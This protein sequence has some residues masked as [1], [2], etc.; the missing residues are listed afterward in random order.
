MKTRIVVAMAAAGLIPF[1]GSLHA[2]VLCTK[3]SGAVI[4][5]TGDSCGRKETRLSPATLGLQAPA[6][7]AG[8][9]GPPGQDGQDG[10]D[11]G[12]SLLPIAFGV[13]DADGSFVSGTDNVE[14][15]LRGDNRFEIRIADRF[16]T[17]DDFVTVATAVSTAFRTTT[18]AATSTGNLVVTIFDASGSPVADNFSFAIFEP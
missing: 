17:V 1:S 9:P 6:G 11:A 15:V 14:S 18:T 12:T 5:R 4:V 13:V 3:K 16:Y 7:P 2:S 8:P 10:E